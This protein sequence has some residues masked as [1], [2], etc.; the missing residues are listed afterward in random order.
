MTRSTVE[1]LQDIVDWMQNALS[2]VEDVD[3]Q[4][5]GVQVHV[6][7]CVLVQAGTYDSTVR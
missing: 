7:S 6:R 1:F 2:F 3:R 4:E 5:D